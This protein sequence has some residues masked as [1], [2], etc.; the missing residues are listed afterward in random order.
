G[1]AEVAELDPRLEED[2]GIDEDDRDV[3]P[4]V[5]VD[6]P[7][8]ALTAR[9]READA[10]GRTFSRV[11]PDQ[12]VAPVREDVPVGDQEQ[13]VALG[14]RGRAIP[15]VEAD[16]E[17]GAD[18][19]VPDGLAVGTGG[20]YGDGGVQIAAREERHASVSQ[21]S[22]G[23]SPGLHASCPAGAGSSKFWHPPPLGKRID[24][25]D[26]GRPCPTR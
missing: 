13:P 15:V 3:D 8:P 25:D 9:E 22:A 1:G 5:R 4:L 7:A 26:N 17:A 2:A 20:L 6:R 23:P 16:E 10:P 14:A 19:P 21:A 12:Q 24:L 18:R 11:D